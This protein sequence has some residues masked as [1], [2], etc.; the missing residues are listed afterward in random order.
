M[1]FPQEFDCE[2]R[3]MKGFENPIANHL[4]K[5][6]CTR[7]TE[8]PISE[9]FPNEQLFIVPYD[10]WYVDIVN[11]LMSDKLSEGWNKHDVLK[12]HIWEDPLPI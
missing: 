11:S 12:L 3:D 6:V 1:L 9:G 7:G 8:T 4:Y 5:I 2:I 10:P